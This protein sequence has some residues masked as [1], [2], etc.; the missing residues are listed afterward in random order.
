[1]SESCSLFCI[2]DYLLCSFDT[3]DGLGKGAQVSP[4][5][6]PLNLPSYLWTLKIEDCSDRNGSFEKRINFR[7]FSR[8]FIK[9]KTNNLK[10]SESSPLSKRAS[11]E[12]FVTISRTFVVELVKTYHSEPIKRQPL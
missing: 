9:Y 4:S 2:L 1:M 3:T 12:W 11:V 7:V 10:K 8:Y 5:P 6:T